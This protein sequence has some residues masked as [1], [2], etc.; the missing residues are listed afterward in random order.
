MLT[1]EENERLTRV[2]RGTPMGDLMRRFWLPF[3]LTADLSEPDG[4]PVRVGLLGE[5]LLAFRDT[6]GRI[7]LI[8]RNCAHRC[9]DLFFGRN[10]EN[11]LRCTY[12]GWKYDVDGRCL[13]MPTED[14]E[15]A[16]KENIKLT[17]YPVRERAGIL[18]TYMGPKEQIPE[19]PEFE[20][21][22]VPEGHRFIS[23]NFQQNN[24]V[25]AIDGGIDTVHSVFLHS[26]LDSHRRLG[27][28]QE[29]AK[30]DRDARL[31]HRVRTNP[32]KLVAK[33]TDYGVLIGGKYRGREGTD[34]WRYNNFLMPFYTMPP[35]GGSGLSK[36]IAHAFVPIDDE[37]CMRWVFTWNFAEPLSAKEIAE[38]RA[39]SSVHVEFIPGTHHPARNMSNDYLID[40]E[41]QK[42][43][44]FTGIKGIGEQDFSVQEGMGRVV[45]R[46]REH[47]GSSDIGI[48][49]MRRR[50]LKAAA[51]LQ[52]GVTPYAALHGEVYHIR[53][54]ELVLPADAQW[55]ENEKLKA[56]MT[57][58]W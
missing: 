6:S 18:W 58:Q 12:H 24:F 46:T 1:R 16:F 28:W 33:D 3:L 52:E 14:A 57:A 19:L 32:P 27:E 11:G 15:S 41:L 25:Q 2:D 43:L 53:S 56:A 55:D 23:W 30:R 31:M 42:T 44:T 26:S 21:A 7:G 50:L 51:D 37:S 20:W 47:L 10:E 48:A 8:D 17:A 13:D 5:R 49:A 45:D 40:R 38:M 54:A 35:G 39:G 34:Y 36:K 9:A 29:Q 22:R 4:A